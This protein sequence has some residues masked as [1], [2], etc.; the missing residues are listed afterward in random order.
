[1]FRKTFRERQQLLHA[2]HVL[3]RKNCPARALL[4]P[5]RPNAH[6]QRSHGNLSSVALPLNFFQAHNV[7]FRQSRSIFLQRMPRNVKAEHRILARKPFLFAPQRCL[8]QQKRGW[9]LRCA[10][11]KKQPMLA[12][13]SQSCGS[14]QCR[15][16]IVHRSCHRFARSKRIHRARFDQAFEYSL[17]Q[18]SRFN[19]L[20]KIVERLKFPA[21]KSRIAN[22][23]RRVLSHVFDRCQAE[24]DRLS[25]WREIQIAL[26]YIR[27]Q[28]RN[29][30]AARL[31]DVLHCFLRISRFGCQQRGHEF[32]GIMRLH[33][34][35]LVS[36][37]G[38]R[39][40][41]RLIEAVARELFH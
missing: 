27:R 29:A 41:V 39:A 37:Q 7:P 4:R 13:V 5:H 9:C 2:G 8:S 26:I 35:R 25:H 18:K 22:R 3:N 30:H 12:G 14:L 40:R 36:K 23:L 17:V 11:S 19:A 21:R 24:P 34:R 1:M 20:T 10:P 32:H 28:D 16:R 15:Q 38:I 6:N 33:V 31:V